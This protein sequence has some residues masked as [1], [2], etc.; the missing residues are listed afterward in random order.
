MA[1]FQIE[2]GT[3]MWPVPA[4]KPKPSTPGPPRFFVKMPPEMM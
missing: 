2:S 4:M 1:I 3:A